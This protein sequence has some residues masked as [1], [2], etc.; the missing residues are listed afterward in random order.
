MVLALVLAFSTSACSSR[1]PKAKTAE[2][3]ISKY[4]KKYGKEYKETDFGKYAIDEVEVNKLTE[5]QRGMAQ[6]ISFISLGDGEIVYKVSVTLTHQ[7]I[8]WKVTA[9]E[10]LGKAE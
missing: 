10:N 4:F 3:A 7:T 8:R 1:L 9:W 6:A 2:H 5:M